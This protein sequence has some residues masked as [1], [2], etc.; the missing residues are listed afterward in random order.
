MKKNRNKLLKG[1]G[2]MV[3]IFSSLA[4]S[5]YLIST[6]ADYEHFKITVDKYSNTLSSTYQEKIDTL[7][8]TYNKL[9]QKILSNKKS[10]ILE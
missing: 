1:S 4:T 2:I 6:F 3:I 5:V 7:D 8:N 10:Y 9:E